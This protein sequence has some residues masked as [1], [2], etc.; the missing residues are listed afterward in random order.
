MVYLR[1]LILHH[2]SLILHY[3]MI[4]KTANQLFSLCPCTFS[5]SYVEKDGLAAAS[6]PRYPPRRERIPHISLPAR[7]VRVATTPT[8]LRLRLSI[9]PRGTSRRTMSLVVIPAS[10]FA[11]GINVNDEPWF[12][13]KTMVPRFLYVSLGTYAIQGK[14]KVSPTGP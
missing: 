10:Q 13:P 6:V 8:A 1:R 5:F 11:I 14:R 9:R 2:C 12:A 3:T 7:H 4:Y